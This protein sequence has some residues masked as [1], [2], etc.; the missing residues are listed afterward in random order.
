[1]KKLL[2]IFSV[3]L[4]L[5]SAA[6]AQINKGAIISLFGSKNLSDDPL[7]TKLYEALLKDSSFNISGTVNEFERIIQEKMVP[8]FP[9][10]FMDKKDVVG[11]AEYQKLESNVI[12]N[13]NAKDED[14]TWQGIMNPYVAADDYRVLAAWGILNDKK[15]I[16]KTFELFPGVDAVMI[17]YINYNIYDAAGA[18]GL[19]S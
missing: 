13:A 4:L 3:A 2:F 10:P 9:F 15:A 16:Q 6:E 14:G 11:N 8:G 12:A 17:G 19:S 1:M 5:S 18:M 7:E